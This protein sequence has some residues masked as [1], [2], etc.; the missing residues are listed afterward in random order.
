MMLILVMVG[1][2]YGYYWLMQNQA[3]KAKLRT[4][5]SSSLLQ[6]TNGNETLVLRGVII[7]NEGHYYLRLE[8]GELV[9]LSSASLMLSAF[10]EKEVEITGSFYREQLV[11]TK[12][13][14]VE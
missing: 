6:S 10:L 8:N 1:L 7:T 12:V 9:E 11:V 3:D 2:I 4:T 13:D 5:G 14:E